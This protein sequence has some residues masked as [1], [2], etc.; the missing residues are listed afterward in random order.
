MRGNEEK[1]PR[2]QAAVI[3]TTAA[4]ALCICGFAT[5]LLLEQPILALTPVLCGVAIAV[6]LPRASFAVVVFV[7]AMAIVFPGFWDTE[8]GQWLPRMVAGVGLGFTA[9]ATILAPDVH[10]VE[11]FSMDDET[12]GL[13]EYE[14]PSTLIRAD[15]QGENLAQTSN[16]FDYDFL[17]EQQDVGLGDAEVMLRRLRNSGRFDDDQLQLIETELR[18]VATKPH[19]LESGDQVGEFVVEGPLGRGG[20]GDVYRGRDRQSGQPAAIK[21]LH[22]VRVGDRFRREMEM[23]QQLAHP[24]IVTAYDV[25]EH[26]GVQYIAME[27]LNGPD[28]N[29]WVNDHGPLDCMTSAR[30]ILQI[31]RALG[32]AHR[33]DLVHRDIKPGN[34]IL[35]GDDMVKL[36]D[37]GLAVMPV[38]GA[39]G[40][41]NQ[42]TK[43]GHLAGTLAYM[44]PEQARSLSSAN[45][46]S[47]IYGLGA[48]W[49]FLLT[50]RPRLRGQSF[51]QQFEN[52]LIKRRFNALPEDCLPESLERVYRRMVAYNPGRRYQH[53]GELTAE[54]EEALVIEGESVSPNEIRV[55]VV[56]DSKT[57]MLLTIETLRRAN[58]SLEIHQAKTLQEGIDV[59][60]SRP[61]D[62]VL[63]DLT[64]PDSIGVETVTTFREAAPKVPLV[65]LTGLSEVEMATACLEAG[66]SGFVSKAGLNV[67][68]MERAIFVTLSRCGVAG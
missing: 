57:D 8:G 67:H 3:R 39:L 34:I 49:Y 41:L 9:I 6:P 44:A 59:M 60:G 40:D 43:E 32:H 63:L 68:K 33:R 10:P 35:N 28:L 61:I 12:D 48:T 4:I 11:T 20:V 26:D 22:N 51:N 52:L 30:Y 37:L 31:A 53:C 50:G 62:L 1:G 36:V 13:D 16:D 19:S 64:L 55:L 15:G 24:N 65:V 25:G 29:V 38:K 18:A 54:L 17:V 42:E 7:A 14:E 56:E 47:D 45:A 66:A 27:L 58:G 2:S 46:T 21:I 5:D 23:V